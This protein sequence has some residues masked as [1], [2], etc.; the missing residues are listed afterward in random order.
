[1]LYRVT[2][3]VEYQSLAELTVA[4]LFDENGIR[5]EAKNVKEFTIEV[6]EK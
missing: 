5:D 2:K 4:E 3:L 1:M 6:V